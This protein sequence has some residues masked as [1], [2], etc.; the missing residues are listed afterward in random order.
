MAN[1]KPSSSFLGIVDTAGLNLVSHQSITSSTANMVFTDLTDEFHILYLWNVKPVTNAVN[2]KVEWSIDNGS[3]Y[4]S[5]LYGRT[6][7][8]NDVG[9][10]ITNISS[11]AADSSLLL[12]GSETMSNTASGSVF[13]LEF[14]R[15]KLNTTELMGMF[16]G[17][18]RGSSST[19][20]QITGSFQKYSLSSSDV[21]AFRISFSSGNIATMQAS[22]FSVSTA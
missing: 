11:N 7:Y 16:H 10:T 12:S 3:T 14:D 9:A 1:T 17:T 4:L 5:T 8:T 19:M 2:L 20:D 13:R 15:A 6:A 18:V 22:L 21:D